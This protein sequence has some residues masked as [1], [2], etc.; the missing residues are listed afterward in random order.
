VKFE[1]TKEEIGDLKSISV[2]MKKL[3]LIFF[4]RQYIKIAASSFIQMYSN[5]F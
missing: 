4:V 1:T 3:F 2:E 5:I